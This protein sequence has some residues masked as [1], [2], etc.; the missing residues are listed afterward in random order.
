MYQEL[1]CMSSSIPAKLSNL[2]NPYPSV[3]DY[4]CFWFVLF[5]Y[6]ITDTG[7]KMCVQTSGFAKDTSQIKQLW[8]IFT[9]YRD[10]QL[11]VGWNLKKLTQQ[12]KG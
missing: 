4:C 10:P 8:A 11:Q 3:H 5:V 2:F 12:D 9:H 7:N 1:S 6:Q